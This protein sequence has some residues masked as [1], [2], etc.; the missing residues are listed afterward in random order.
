MQYEINPAPKMIQSKIMYHRRYMSTSIGY[1]C[2]CDDVERPK[3]T[4]AR[5]FTDKRI[6]THFGH[7]DFDSHEGKF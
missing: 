1:L 6:P 4:R 5:V 7:F 3:V 2:V